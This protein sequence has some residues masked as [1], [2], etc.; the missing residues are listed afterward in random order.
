MG[1]EPHARLAAKLDA[2]ADAAPALGG[3]PL[4]LFTVP[5][6]RREAHL[7]QHLATH[8]ALDTVDVATTARDYTHPGGPAHHP[9]NQVWLRL[10]RPAH[11]QRLADLPGQDQTAA[12]RRCAAEAFA[13]PPAPHPLGPAHAT[14][15][16]ATAP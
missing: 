15:S 12:A 13:G 9:T 4:I 14:E 7:H 11:R 2:Y 16:K 6:V 1:T 3:R 8:P 5:A 10:G